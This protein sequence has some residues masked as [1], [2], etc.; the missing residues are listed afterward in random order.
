M[1][2]LLLLSLFILLNALQ[3]AWAQ[4]RQITGRVTDRQSGEGLPG[5]TVLVKGT[6]VG[7]S[8]GAD[9]NFTLSAPPTAATLTFSS[10]GYATIEQPI[11]AGN[12]YNVTLATDTKQLN[13]VV[14][15]ALGIEKDT[16][17]LGYSTQQIKAEQISQKSEPNVLNSLQGKVSGV[18]ISSAS[19]LPGSSTNINIRGITSLQGSN[20]P[21]F[22]VDGIPISNDLERGFGGGGQGSLGAA[23]VSNR[24]LDIDP[25]SIASINILKGPAAAAL[26]GSRA[27][28][29]AI[30]ITTKNGG[31]ANKKL[32]VTATSSFNVQNVYGTARLQ[33]EYGQGNNGVVTTT[34]GLGDIYTANSN[35]FGPRFGT[36]PTLANGL[37]LTNG[38][39]LPYQNYPNNIRDFYRQGTILTNGANIAGGNADQNVSLNVSNT[40]QKGIVQNSELNRTNVLLGGNVKLVNKLKAGGSVS[41]IQTNQSGVGQGNFNSPFSAL[42]FAVPR[43]LNLQGNPY[44]DPLTGANVFFPGVESPYFG[45][46]QNTTKSAVTRF[47]NVANL[48]YDVTPWLN[49]LYRAGLDTYTDRRKTVYVAGSGRNP[50]GLIQDQ[51]LYRSEFNSDIIVTAKKDNLFSEGLNASL[52]VGQNVNQRRTQSITSQSENLAVPGFFN[53]QVGSVFQNGTGENTSLRRILGVY[54]Q[55]TLG[56]NNYLFLELTGRVDQSSTLPKANNTFFYPSATASFVFTDALKISNNIFSYGKLRANISK[57]G[58]DA[59]PYSLATVYRSGSVGNNVSSI[60]FPFSN[61]NGNFPGFVINNTIGGGD[62]LKP[63]S[64]KSYEVGTN[65]GFFNNRLSFELT[66]FYTRSVDQIIPVSIASSSGFGTLFANVGRV[67]N[68]GF[69]GIMLVNPVKTSAFR[70]DISANFTRIKNEVI[71]IAPGITTSTIAGGGFIGSQPSFREHQP[72]GVI[73]GNALPRVPAKDPVTGKDNDPSI[74]GKYIINP[75]SGTFAPGVANSIIANPNPLWQGGIT[76]TFNYRG[77]EFSFLVDAKYGGEVLSFTNASLKASGNLY[78]TGINRDAPRIIPGVIRNADGTYRPNNIEID[79]QAYWGASG[80]LQSQLNVYDASIYRL[81]E[82][83]LGYSLPK[84]LLERTPFG[85]VRFSVS[86]RNLLYY[87]PNANFDPELNTQGAGNIRGLDLQGS[88]NTRNYGVNLRFTL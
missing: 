46:N 30:I 12:T 6:T 45:V 9:G 29:G 42:S 67:D 41:F 2:N 58:K 19:G 79:A 44:V 66:G 51:A 77:V 72:Y 16:R 81:R 35:S 48:S 47:I 3:V 17:S 28:S 5:V 70:W 74:V 40:T 59:D 25:E 20:Q 87:A 38:S 75:T 27:S 88:P 60:N 18:N 8:T 62:I 15:T 21:L 52:L 61:A 31:S 33:N 39:L 83:S 85:Q 78:E 37:L 73:I 4:N 50:L 26:Y 71:S 43:S 32:E 80:G 84:D 76:N 55:L 24:A 64:T 68:T 34:G 13:E 86:G 36:A 11:G 54:S 82:V 22:V 49:V 56:Y 53:S 1:K 10:I 23:Q 69:E 14:V 65:L 57:V 7:T 63:E